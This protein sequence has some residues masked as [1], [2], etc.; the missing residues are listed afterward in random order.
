MVVELDLNLSFRSTGFLRD[1]CGKR[2]FLI[3]D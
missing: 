2:V 3:N 1:E